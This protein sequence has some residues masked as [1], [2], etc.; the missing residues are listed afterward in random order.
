MIRA[1]GY[2]RETAA[3][4]RS[5]RRD[6]LHVPSDSA[7]SAGRALW[8]SDPVAFDRAEGQA[9]RA[10][11]IADHSR[12]SRLINVAP[13][14][15]ILARQTRPPR[16]NP[17]GA[18]RYRAIPRVPA[19]DTHGYR[20]TAYVRTCIVH[21]RLTVATIEND[22]APPQVTRH[23]RLLDIHSP[24]RPSAILR[25]LRLSRE[26][27]RER[28]GRGKRLRPSRGYASR[29]KQA[30]CRPATSRISKTKSPGLKPFLS[31][32]SFLPRVT[33]KIRVAAKVP[34][35]RSGLLFLSLLEGG[36]EVFVT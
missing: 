21:S 29:S 18:R 26:V 20:I 28:G 2:Y 35:L 31:T 33:R 3:V 13:D 17:R 36:F 34:T 32:A 27:R 6:P 11:S 30:P 24:A 14:A 4:P 8:R 9:P 7:I 25:E 19:S 23:D 1:G 22:L 5:S 16:E 12:P 15:P 10:A